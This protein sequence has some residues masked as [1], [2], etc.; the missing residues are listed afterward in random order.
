LLIN[1]ITTVQV[2]KFIAGNLTAFWLIY[3]SL[4]RFK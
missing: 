4:F 1:F 3:G 2:V